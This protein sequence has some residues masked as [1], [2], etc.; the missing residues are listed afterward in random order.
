M[1]EI[2]ILVYV[3]T[4]LLIVGSSI[5]AIFPL[6]KNLN[7]RLWG[8]SGNGDTASNN[9]TPLK[10]FGQWTSRQRFRRTA[11]EDDETTLTRGDAG[12]GGSNISLEGIVKTTD[13]EQTWGPADSAPKSAE[14]KVGLTRG[15]L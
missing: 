1:C 5:A 4:T 11:V 3:E 10:T 14:R 15:M 6:F 9:A 13:V 12:R 8:T 7:L 2:Y